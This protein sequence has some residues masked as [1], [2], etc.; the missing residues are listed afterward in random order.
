[1]LRRLALA[2]ALLA[3]AG[4]SVAA[5]LGWRYYRELDAE[6]VEKFSGRRWDFPSKIY[7]DWTLL[8][9]GTDIKAIGLWERLRRLQ[10][11]T[12]DGEV[13]HPGEAHRDPKTGTVELYLRD[14]TYPDGRQPP[15]SVRLQLDGSVIRAITDDS[16]ADVISV[17]IEP[18]LLAGL[19]EGSWEQRRVLTLDQLPAN[20][21]NAIL[22]VED[23]RFFKHHGIDP[24]GVARALW[25][26]ITTGHLL[27]GGS[28]LTQQL[29]KNF[30]LTEE[31][32]MKRKLREAAMALIAEHRY[33]KRE[34]LENY[35]N[36]IYLGQ[37]GAQG[38]YGMWE[39]ARFY[40]HKEPV[41]LTPAEC[42]LLAGLIR[43]PNY[44][45]PFAHPA[46]ALRRRNYVLQ[47]MHKGDLISNTEFDDAVR[48]PIT[49]VPPPEDRADAP[50]FVDFLRKELAATYPSEVLTREG[51]SVFTGLDP[52]LQQIAEKSLQK[53]LNDLER[54]YPR[55]VRGE[56][57]IQGC[58]IAIQPQT[59]EIKAM[60]GG[61]DYRS[62][63]FNRVIQAFR[64]PGS[65]FKPFT[66]IAALEHAPGEP[67]I[68]PTT[69]LDDEQ[70]TWQY[71][72]KEWS[73]ANY[74]DVYFGAVTVRQALERSLNAATARL[75]QEVGLERIRDV[76][77]RMGITSPLPLY[78]SMVLGAADVSPME[79]AQAYAVLANQGLRAR[80]LAV[81][82]VIDHQGQIIERNP[83]EIERAISPQVAYLVT[84]LMEGV[85][86]HGTGEGAR[87]LGF[88]RPAAGKTGTTN[89]NRDA[90]FAGFTPDLLAVVW[91]GFDEQ[92]PLGLTGA[93]AA[94]PIWTEFMKQATA[95]TPVSHFIPPPGVRLVRI[96]PDTGE[97]ATPACP[98]VIEEAFLAGDEPTTPC[99]RHASLIVEPEDV[100]PPIMPA[101]EP[102]VRP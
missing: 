100:R 61:R 101:T 48:E 18:E 78:P 33:S 50:Y 63:Q 27:Q 7:A 47:Q 21:I 85:I 31:R 12:V 3:L 36:E 68:L 86:D 84:H 4:I 40:F 25:V 20:L 23:R 8:Y 14:F 60:M 55:L 15:R 71:G 26:D 22:A 28:T 53:G 96:D 90:W 1:M 43:A 49:V 54:R 39:A 34:I 66:Y 83:V 88:K 102:M 37:N 98:R 35:I 9:P 65:V 95:G 45:S 6:L 5:F 73:P 82:S 42:A 13:E 93:Q 57:R 44:Y 2:T 16:G 58:L 89:D 52:Q 11:R 38:I 17:E 59:G 80:P 81:R 76:A 92:R 24:M 64:Q 67:R 41:A 87:E 74:K 69:V 91:V 94:L 19:Y 46:R 75:A 99:S 51:L 79:V 56:Q 97:L 30:F 62:T 77:Q 29:M 32:T 70:F 10:Y 72:D